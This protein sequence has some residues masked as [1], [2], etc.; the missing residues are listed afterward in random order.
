MGSRSERIYIVEDEA[1][2]ALELQD[3]LSRLGYTVCGTAARGEEAVQA[4]PALAPGLVLMDIKLAGD[5]DGVDTA[6]RVRERAD[7]PVVVLTAYA[8]DELLRRIS[9]IEPFGYLVK[10]FAE[11]E[12]HATIQAALYR[13]RLD[14]SLR[15]ANAG[16]EERVRERTAELEA[17]N[18]ALRRHEAALERALADREVALREIHHRVKNNLQ[19]ASSLLSVQFRDLADAEIQ[20]RVRESQQRVRAIALVHEKLYQEPTLSS[21]AL[22]QYLKSLTRALTMASHPM[23][24]TS[25]TIDLDRVVT[26]IDLAL[27][28]GLILNELVTNA[29]KH[30]RKDEH[31]TVEVSVS[32]QARPSGFV[33]TVAG[34][35]AWPE[36]AAG[37]SGIGLQLVKDLATQLSA[38][39][40]VV[41]GDAARVH[42]DVPLPARPAES[43]A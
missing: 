5:L 25:L 34:S 27:R 36:A 14:L 2:V 24:R 1:L 43:D 28:T 29:I 20:R 31:D 19:L 35:G 23:L 22:D 40:R 15:Q 11:R 6:R 12:L 16:L 32:L 13:H 8:D 30:G 37:D 17:S 9:E 38:S 10:P 42:V 18:E 21:I 7:V 3:R 26:D 33:L 4:V 41:K 39:V